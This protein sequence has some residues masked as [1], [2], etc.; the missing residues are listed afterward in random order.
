MTWAPLVA[1]SCD[2][3]LPGCHPGSSGTG[4]FVGI[5]VL[6]A[7]ALIVAGLILLIVFLVRR[8]GRARRAV[9]TPGFA[10]GWYPDPSGQPQWRWWDGQ[11]WTDQVSSGGPQQTTGGH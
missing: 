8:R 6:I 5:V 1:D 9:A 11:T 7:A 4:A 10:A 3:R 2:P